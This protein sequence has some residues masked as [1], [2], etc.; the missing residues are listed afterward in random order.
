M[1]KEV[2]KKKESNWL[3]IG[4]SIFVGL[5][6]VIG[7]TQSLYGV[8]KPVLAPTPSPTPTAEYMKGL[9][10]LFCSERQG[11]TTY[12]VFICVGCANLDDINNFLTSSKGVA[13]HQALGPAK[14]ESCDKVA[15]ACMKRWDETTCTNL[16]GRK[17]WLGMT[18]DELI[19]SS[20]L[21]DKQNDSIGK[22]GYESQWVYGNP[23]YGAAYIYLEGKDEPSSKVTSYQD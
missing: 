15:K 16:A 18:R 3:I 5:G 11:I 22:W 17:Y 4:I 7:I 10:D 21:P 13:I 6:I 19:V 20:G 14:K 23:I 1:E 12:G 9:S 8:L 2:Q